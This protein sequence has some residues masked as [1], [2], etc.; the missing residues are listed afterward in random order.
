MRVEK[1]LV[2]SKPD[3]TGIVK[4]SG[5]LGWGHFATT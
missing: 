3:L 4:N 1:M 5:L 2:K